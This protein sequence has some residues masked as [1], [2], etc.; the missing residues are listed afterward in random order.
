MGP[1]HLRPIAGDRADPPTHLRVSQKKVDTARGRSHRTRRLITEVFPPRAGKRIPAGK[2]GELTVEV[3][4]NQ[5]GDAP[6][7][8]G[9]SYGLSH[10][11]RGVTGGSLGL[12]N[13]TIDI[14]QPP[15]AVPTSVP[16]HGDGPWVRRHRVA[17]GS[18]TDAHYRADQDCSAGVGRALKQLP[19]ALPT[20]PAHLA[21]SFEMCFLAQQN[22]PLHLGDG[23]PM[24]AKTPTVEDQHSPRVSR[25]L[26]ARRRSRPN[27]SRG[28][29][30]NAGPSHPRE[31]RK[32]TQEQ[33]ERA[34]AQGQGAARPPKAAAGVT[35]AAPN[36][37]GGGGPQ[38]RPPEAWRLKGPQRRTRR[39]R[40][41]PLRAYQAPAGR[42]PPQAASGGCYRA[43]WCRRFPAPHAVGPTA[44]TPPSP[45]SLLHHPQA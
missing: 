16:T 25:L 4:N 27:R 43:G 29:G 26:R 9:L 31:G 13:I 12:S 7:P 42:S 40:H 44:P 17:H 32:P 30:V 39:G 1:P 22:V 21:C 5:G 2:L 20:R 35:H 36:S 11:G 18:R 6:A 38:T 41:P 34:H 3:P 28:A 8:F 37:P 19:A 33:Q 24:R 14:G 10:K 45:A 15:C 23:I